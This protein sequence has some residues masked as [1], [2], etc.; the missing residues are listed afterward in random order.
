MAVLFLF[1][2]SARC[3]AADSTAASDTA[4]QDVAQLTPGDL[5]AMAGDMAV[6][7]LVLLSE[8]MRNEAVA[9]P[10]GNSACAEAARLPA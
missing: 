6:A 7:L 2:G 1:C 5:P 8:S 3:E 9:R 10:A 4:A